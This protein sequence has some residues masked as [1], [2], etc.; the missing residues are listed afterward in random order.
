MLGDNMDEPTVLDYVK[1]LLTPWKKSSIQFPAIESTEDISDDVAGMAAEDISPPDKY[2]PVVET[3][4]IEPVHKEVAGSIS[5]PWRAGTSLLVGMGAQ[6]VLAPPQRAP[7]IGI[8]LLLISAWLV[9]WAFLCG[10]WKTAPPPETKLFKDPLKMD[11]P[12]FGIGILFALLTFITSGGNRFSLLNLAFLLLSLVFLFRALWRKESS[13]K[14]FLSNLT[15]SLKHRQWQFSISGWFVLLIVSTFLVLVFRVKDLSVLPPEMVSDHAEKYLDVINILNGN[16]QIF[17]PRNGG[18]EAL[19]FYLIS[20]LLL[21]FNTGINFLTLKISTVLIGLLALPFFYLLG[22]EI[23]GRRTGYITFVFA[24]TAYWLNVV[25]RAGMRLPFYVLF[26]AAALYFLIKGLNSSNRNDFLICGLVLGLGMYGYSANRILPFLIFAGVI[27]FLLHKK[28]QGYRRQVLGQT[29]ILFLI[30]LVAYL[31]LLRYSIQ[32]PAG[33]AGRMISR[34]GTS[35]AV[36]P[37]QLLS[38]FA[39]NSFDALSMFS[40]S[41]GV[42]WVTSVPDYPALSIIAGAFFYAGAVLILLRYVYNRRWMDIFLLL[43]IPILLLPSILSLAYP[44]ENPNLYRTGG[45]AVPVFLI[46]G[47]AFDSLMSGLEE[48]FSPAWGSSLA[49]GIFTALFIMSAILNYDLVFNK[50]YEQY[51]LS[52]QNT[53][54]MGEVIRGFVDTGGDPGSVWVMG[55]PHWADTRLVSINAGYP[56]TDFALFTDQIGDTRQ[57][58]DPKLFI[59][60]P[61]DKTSIDTLLKFYEDGWFQRYNAAVQAKDF[62]I[63]FVPGN[64]SGE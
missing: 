50:Y 6:W 63:Y 24:G 1:S 16:T 46:I 64:E 7:L 34:L 25:S 12:S 29:G 22:K 43:S 15:S 54:E 48:R 40:W 56:F 57:S 17:F 41:A 5:I 39:V 13:K 20:S 35:G 42:V 8:I 62:L 33:Y 4:Q 61:E 31:P 3:D 26:S 58:P 44:G 2:T 55:Y 23:G 30:A 10:E 11:I 60:H 36:P 59:V 21:L 49:W 14:N 52:A 9:V 47:L 45:A 18:R 19:Q 37:A 28:S 32:D 38:T 27:L 53:S 51:R